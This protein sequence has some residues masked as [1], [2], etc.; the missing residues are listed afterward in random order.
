MAMHSKR[1]ALLPQTIA[2]LALNTLNLGI[3]AL[4]GAGY[5]WPVWPA[6]LWGVVLA[7]SVWAAFSSP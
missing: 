4:T 3:W 6:L 7:I 2:Y 5:L 1:R